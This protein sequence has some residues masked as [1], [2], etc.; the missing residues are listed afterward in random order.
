MSII[1]LTHTEGEE[2]PLA[3][4][5]PGTDTHGVPAHLVQHHPDPV[6]LVGGHQH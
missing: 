2:G 4:D 5:P 3:V 6:D 1:G